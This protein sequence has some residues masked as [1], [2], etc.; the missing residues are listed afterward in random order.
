M[1]QINTRHRIS[2]DK[3][4]VTGAQ[5][6]IMATLEKPIEV[7]LVSCEVCLKEVPIAEAAIA[8]ATD[9][10]AYFCGLECYEKWKSRGEGTAPAAVRAAGP[11]AA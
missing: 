7:D 3:V 10:F 9:Y 1:S 5:E 6:Q 4:R 8:E 11:R 2:G